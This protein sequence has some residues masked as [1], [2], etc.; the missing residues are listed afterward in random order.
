MSTQSI[1]HLYIFA[2][3]LKND[4]DLLNEVYY[5]SGVYG[6]IHIPTCK[7]YVGSSSQIG[8]RV[9]GGLTEY[10]N[11]L[12]RNLLIEDMRFVVLE[13]CNDYLRQ[14]EKFWIETLGLNQGLN[15]SDPE[16]PRFTGG[17]NTGSVERNP[18]I[19]ERN[20]KHKEKISLLSDGPIQPFHRKKSNQTVQRLKEKFK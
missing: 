1:T 19:L 6:L 20:L 7:M 2:T 13:L 18:A 10:D 11:V 12:M 17:E 9:W 4:I 15:I 3:M 8:A 5:K 16:K 14:R